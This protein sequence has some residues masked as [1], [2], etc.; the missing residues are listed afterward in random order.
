MVQ[1]EEQVRMDK[2]MGKPGSELG[3]NLILLTMLQNHENKTV[4]MVGTFIDY[5]NRNLDNGFPF[6]RFCPVLLNRIELDGWRPLLHARPII[7]RRRSTRNGIALR[8]K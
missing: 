7:P 6:Y 2:W 4:E 8:F 5:W 3:K 1:V